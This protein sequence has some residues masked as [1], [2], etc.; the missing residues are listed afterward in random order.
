VFGYNFLVRRNKRGLDM[1]RKFAKKVLF[2]L[3]SSDA[4]GV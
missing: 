1:V 2:V 3:L 4:A